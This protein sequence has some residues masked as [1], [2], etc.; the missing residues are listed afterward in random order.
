MK[1]GDPSAQR[2][3]REPALHFALLGAALFAAH[4]AL[5][6]PEEDADATTPIVIS[7]AFLE[8]LRERH[9][10]R[11]GSDAEDEA[12]IA[13]YARDEALHREALRLGLDRGDAIVRRRLI[14]KMELLLRAMAEP[15]ALGDDALAA[16]L[17]ANQ[18]AY[19][20][21][22][23]A[24]FTLAWFSR[25]QRDDAESDARAALAAEAP[26]GDPFLLGSRF[27]GRTRRDVRGRLGP[28]LAG[29]AFSAPIGRWSGP[30]L[31]SRGVFL[32]RV[33]ARE[34]GR[35][36]TLDE[37]REAVARDARREAADRALQRAVSTLVE[38]YGVER[39]P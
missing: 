11:A 13:E 23:R 20:A 28:E 5:V 1:R 31:T 4:A 37:A 6:A 8:G 17:E 2:W 18:A 38:R 27:E 12:L 15:E 3:M 19:R 16:H 9:R 22:D 10:R 7:D 32:I 34:E 39:T 36:A 21:P 25:D 30:V 29:A 33:D 35:P 24:S 14:Q 26:E